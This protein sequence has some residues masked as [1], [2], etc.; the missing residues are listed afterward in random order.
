[1]KNKKV[2]IFMAVVIGIL[3]FFLFKSKG[4]SSVS[5]EGASTAKVDKTGKKIAYYQSPMDPTYIS[6]KPGK[7]TM[8]MDMVPVY[9]GEE[10]PAGGVRIDPATVQNI[11][12]RSEVIAKRVLKRN[13]RAVGR[14]T[15]DEKKVAYIN[16]KIGGWIEKLY[17]DY[18]GQDVKKDDPLLEIYSPELV[19]TQEEYLLAM[20]YNQKMKASNIDE[21]SKRSA[22][23]LESARKRLEYWDVPQKHIEELEKAG[24]VRKTLM[25]HSPATGVIISKT[26][27]EGQY[28]K[29]GENLYRIADL[30]R[31]WVYADIYEYEVPWVKVGQSADM[32]LSYLPGKT[33]R[34]KIT[35]I[36]PYLESKTRTVKVRLEFDNVNGDLKPDMY[37]EVNINTAPSQAVVSVPK[38][39]IIHSGRRKVM[40]IDK[41]EGLFEPRD[42]LIGMET[43]DFYEILHGAKAGELVVTSAQ[44]LIDSESQLT[45]AISKMLKAKKAENQTMKMDMSE[46]EVMRAEESTQK[47]MNDIWGVYFQ[48]RKQLAQDSLLDMNQKISLINNRANAILQADKSLD[49]KSIVEGITSSTKGLTEK[50]I[51]KVREAFLVLS[52]S[53]VQ[54]MKTYMKGDAQEKGYKL[55]F[56]G[57][58]KKSWVQQEEKVGNPYVSAKIAF[59]GAQDSY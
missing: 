48:I 31:I 6:E 49:I 53:M 54:Y 11:G 32:T 51:V 43:K 40:I 19:S 41:G 34:G 4:D 50:D 17:V 14:V 22:S 28:T 45:E 47:A 44:F 55:F 36:Y 20:E 13:I 27:L 58:E 23:L 9:E 46:G 30:S 38:E 37:T 5:Q 21:I 33:F 24:K 1:M 2:L 26:T 10:L 16:T 7:D 18:E 15:Y 52:D 12:V 3:S 25:I 8:G 35:Y 57:M 39:A 29:P 42:V 56:C 59:C